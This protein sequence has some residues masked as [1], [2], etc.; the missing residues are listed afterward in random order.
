LYYVNIYVLTFLFQFTPF[1][2]PLRREDL[3]GTPSPVG[4]VPI[5]IGREG[6]INTYE[7]V[8]LFMITE[9]QRKNIL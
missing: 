6:G 2:V 4:E 7:I 5:A 8:V 9:T 1:P 3:P